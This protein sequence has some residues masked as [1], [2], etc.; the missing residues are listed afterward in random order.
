[1]LT[2]VEIYYCS[3]NRFLNGWYILLN[4]FQTLSSFLAHIIN[5]HAC[6]YK[7]DYQI[8]A[9]F[10]FYEFLNADI[11]KDYVRWETY[12]L[13]WKMNTI[14]WTTTSNVDVQG[15]FGLFVRT[16]DFFMLLAWWAILLVIWGTV[17]FRHIFSEIG[18]HRFCLCS[19][20]SMCA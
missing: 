19:F 11:K 13:G 10:L 3:K 5:G 6:V 12:L 7:T 4:D 1:M 8:V 9:C 2:S 20:T 17:V 18:H 14:L 16:D 15:L